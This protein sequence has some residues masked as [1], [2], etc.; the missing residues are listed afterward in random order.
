MLLQQSFGRLK[1]GRFLFQWYNLLYKTKLAGADEISKTNTCKNLN[2]N[3]LIW[4]QK[5]SK[6]KQIEKRCITYW[7]KKFP[8]EIEQ[9]NKE[10]GEV[11]KSEGILHANTSPE[12]PKEEMK[13]KASQTER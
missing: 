1:L 10:K 6:G 12:N 11:S 5:E 4:K 8:Q 13:P 3:F 9:N 2:L 7:W